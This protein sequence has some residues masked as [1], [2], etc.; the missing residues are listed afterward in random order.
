ME[1]KAFSLFNDGRTSFGVGGRRTGFLIDTGD[2]TPKN[3][4]GT[5]SGSEKR[6][7]ESLWIISR[8]H[9]TVSLRQS[10]PI[11][12]ISVSE[13][14]E[15]LERG[16]ASNPVERATSY[17]SRFLD[18][19][20]DKF[21]KVEDLLRSI[22]EEVRDI[23]SQ[24][25]LRNTRTKNRDTSVVETMTIEN[26]EPG[27]YKI[28]VQNMPVAHR[29]ASS[30]TYHPAQK[31]NVTGEIKINGYQISIDSN[32][33]L[34]TIAEKINRGEDS[35][36]N[37]ALDPS[38]DINGNGE[39][40]IID[41]NAYYTGNSYSKPVFINEDLNGNGILDG[42]EDS[43]NNQRLDGVG[44]ETGVKAIIFD[45][46]LVLVSRIPG[47]VEIRL[48]DPSGIL[49]H[50]GL[51]IRDE[52]TQDVTKNT[53]NENTVAVKVG[54][55]LVNGESHKV[56]DAETLDLIS[57]IIVKLKEEGTAV[58]NVESA[59]QDISSQSVSLVG[60]Y[61]EALDT[62]N[63]AISGHGAISSNLK[64]QTIYTD[65]IKAMF[66][67]PPVK[68]GLYKS[69]A[70][71]GIK[72]NKSEPSSM[73]QITLENLSSTRNDS[74]M[75]PGKGK[76]SLLS[77]I[78]RIGVNSRDNFKLELDKGLMTSSVKK[79]FQSVK[80]MLNFASSRLQQKLDKHLNEDYGT[81]KIQ[82]GV[83]SYYLNNREEASSN[84]RSSA[85]VTKT[86]ISIEKHQKLFGSII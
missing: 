48:E 74:L 38:E 65:V 71:I 77:K 72:D 17:R 62:M 7:A 10:T 83:S 19:Q 8:N 1:N 16:S 69:L 52:L 14:V 37:N 13:S 23:Q 46:Q 64:L 9:P 44:A 32:D 56:N 33:S 82:E 3:S 41:I 29:L 45:N 76:Y 11:N 6:F 22:Q 84:V 80:D 35:N 26:P 25:Y 86:E 79:D 27:N 55:V 67:P 49:E 24:G 66:S 21:R 36:Y 5:I 73:E 12:A 61:N 57:G 34:A 68:F 78:D 2:I 60:R 43:N 63:L 85:E 42:S 58:I 30:K 54:A 50:I 40:D 20:G 47:D 59:P 4:G 75:I 51:L 15:M 53:N 28:E 31:L 70:D 39:L 81:L 18:I